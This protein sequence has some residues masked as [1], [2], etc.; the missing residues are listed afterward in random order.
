MSARAELGL[1]TVQWGLPYGVA[2]NTGQTPSNEVAS[3]LQ[4]ARLGKVNVLDTASQYGEAE[5]ALG[6]NDLDG[7][8]VISKTPSF[9]ASQISS[10]DVDKLL[11]AFRCSLSRLSCSRIDGLLFHRVD[12]VV[13]PGGDSLVAAIKSLQESGQVRKIGVSV[14]DGQQIDAV[15]QVFRP[16]IVQLPINV[17][18]QRLLRSGHLRKLKDAGVEIHARSIFLQG[19]L[20][21]PIERLPAYFQP[22]RP[23]LSK[24]IAAAS[25]QGMTPAQAALSFVRDLAGVDVALIGVESASQFTECQTNFNSACHFDAFDLACDDVE[26]VN[27]M[28][29]SLS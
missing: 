26:L 28:F 3:I 12:D 27:P 5:A 9:C 18:D 20:L 19:L 7:F 17:L 16:D 11:Q 1:G 8:R 15:L 10:E 13:A 22:F 14:Y 6:A 4:A 2:N 24:W 29:W 23:I 25:E 21:M